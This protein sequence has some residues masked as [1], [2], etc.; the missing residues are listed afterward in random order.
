MSHTVEA[1][2]RDLAPLQSFDQRV[3][4]VARASAG[5]DENRG[6]LHRQKVLARDHAARL[7]VERRVIGDEV[8]ALEEFLV[9]NRLAAAEAPVAPGNDLKSL[10]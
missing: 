3:L 2:A 8:A 5:V 10:F 6:R 7:V 9:A 4:V 1:S